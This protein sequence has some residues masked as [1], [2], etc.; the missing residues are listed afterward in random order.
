MLFC[1][2]KT[3]LVLTAPHDVWASGRN[4]ISSARA[5]VLKDDKSKFEVQIDSTP[6]HNVWS[7][8]WVIFHDTCISIAFITPSPDTCSVI[9]VGNAIS[10]FIC[11]DISPLLMTLVFYVTLSI[12]DALDDDESFGWTTT[13]NVVGDQPTS[14]SSNINCS[15]V[16]TNYRAL[17]MALVNRIF[18]CCRRMNLS[19]CGI[20]ALGRPLR[21]RTLVLFVELWRSHRHC[22]MRTLQLKMYVQRVEAVAQNSIFL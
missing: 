18:I 22:M 11:E 1:W 6:H 20:V 4:P 12:V 19:W 21:T 17:C 10:N 8:S 3:L 13:S 2:R 9:C 15:L 7:A 5:D 14:D 16:F